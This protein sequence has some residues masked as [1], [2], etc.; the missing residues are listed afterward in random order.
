MDSVNHPKHY[1]AKDGSMLEVID[2]IEAFKLGYRLGNVI[3]YVLRHDRKNTIEDLKKAVWYLNREIEFLE[4]AERFTEEEKRANAAYK[5][6]TKMK[7][8]E[9]RRWKAQKDFRDHQNDYPY[10]TLTDTYS[11]SGKAYRTIAKTTSPFTDSVAISGSE[12]GVV[13]GGASLGT[14]DTP[15]AEPY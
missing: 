6:L 12:L 11:D 5:A 3:K 1:Q 8:D 7:E 4:A 2:V 15:Q 14:Y 9:D 10:I 13:K